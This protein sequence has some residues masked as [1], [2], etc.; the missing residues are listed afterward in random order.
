MSLVENIK[1]LCSE[2]GTSIPKIEVLLGLSRGSIYNWD[3]NSPS[4]DKLERVANHLKVSVDYLL[5]RGSIF[6]LGPYIE[7]ERHEQGMS[8]EKFSKLLGISEDDLMRYEEQDIPMT[9]ELVKKTMD[10]LGMSLVD[11][12][13]KY[14]LLDEAIPEEFDGDINKYISFEQ[15]REEDAANEPFP[16]PETIAAHKDGEDWTEEE[17]EEIERFKQFV[18]M[19]RSI[20]E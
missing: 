11:F 8:A 4:I 19:K 14:G 13:S 12:R 20:K 9:E 5:D 18:K 17:L 3:K 16:E 6:D 10:I 2:I 7:E 1:F 15:K